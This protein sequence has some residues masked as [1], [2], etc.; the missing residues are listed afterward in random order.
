[1]SGRRILMNCGDFGEDCETMLLFHALA[2][3][4]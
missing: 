1:M 4:G 2:A 3:V